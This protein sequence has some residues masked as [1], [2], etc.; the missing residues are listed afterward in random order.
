MNVKVIIF[1]IIALYIGANLLCGCCKY[2]IFDYML[3]TSKRE[4]MID[5]KDVGTPGSVAS[6]KKLKAIHPRFYQNNKICRRS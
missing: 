3:G 1:F 4:G 6:V 5:N 2:P